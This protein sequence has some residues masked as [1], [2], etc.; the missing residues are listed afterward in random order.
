MQVC[1]RF[2][3]ANSDSC[4][5]IYQINQITQM[6][7]TQMHLIHQCDLRIAFILLFKRER[8]LVIFLKKGT[9]VFKPLFSF[10]H[11]GQIRIWT[12]E[13]KE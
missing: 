12:T 6:G 9:S 5:N 7:F 10:V 3:W 2:S 11:I 4:E 13:P 1:C 8:L